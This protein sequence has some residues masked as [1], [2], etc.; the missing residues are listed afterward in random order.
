MLC[1]IKPLASS[2]FKNSLFGFAIDDMPADEWVITFQLH[3]LRIVAAV[4]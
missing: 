3:P 2:A 1:E 4:F